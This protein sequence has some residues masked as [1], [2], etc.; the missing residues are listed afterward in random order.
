MEQK[1]FIANFFYNEN[2]YSPASIFLSGKFLSYLK[3]VLSRINIM[4]C[5]VNLAILISI[6]L[7][8][9]NK[10]YFSQNEVLD[11]W[12]ISINE[13]KFVLFLLKKKILELI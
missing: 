8:L 12:N 13:K 10:H 5:N 9:P 3:N 6:M 2:K 11:S 1:K 7:Y 4:N